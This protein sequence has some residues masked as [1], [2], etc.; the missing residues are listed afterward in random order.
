MSKLQLVSDWEAWV[1]L[2]DSYD[3]DPYKTIEFGV[4]CGGGNSMDY[5]YTGEIPEEEEIV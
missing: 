5:E 1:D 3:E 2:C 4:D